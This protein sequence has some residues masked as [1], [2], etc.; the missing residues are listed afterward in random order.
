MT[1]HIERDQLGQKFKI[2]FLLFPNWLFFQLNL[3][4]NIFETGRY[5]LEI[6]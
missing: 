1:Q 6:W 2:D 5:V 3:G 4:S